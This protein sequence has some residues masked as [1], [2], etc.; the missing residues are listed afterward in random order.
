[1]V[2]VRQPALVPAHI[3]EDAARHDGGLVRLTLPTPGKRLLLEQLLD[4]P[5]AGK[6]LTVADHRLLDEFAARASRDLIDRLGRLFDATSASGEESGELGL[7][8][9]G[10]EVFRI[11]YSPDAMVALIRGGIEARR[12]PDAPLVSRTEA[13]RPCSAKIEAIVGSVALTLDDLR[14]L[15]PG[16]VLVLDRTTYQPIDLLLSLTRGAIGHGRPTVV[17]GQ[18]AIAF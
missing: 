5:L 14:G 4:E 2:G 1:M 3:L 9:N 11:S 12:R 6:E 10:Q 8:I 18:N 15:E 13:L 17:D 7:T 16:D